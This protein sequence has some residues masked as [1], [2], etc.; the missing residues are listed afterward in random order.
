[1]DPKAI[2]ETVPPTSSSN[3]AS[4]TSPT[5]PRT[6]IGLTGIRPNVAAT[7]VAA[8][9][10]IW[11]IAEVGG[12]A[13]AP[14]LT[15]LA[16]APAP[17]AIA[18]AWKIPA[19]PIPSPGSPAPDIGYNPPSWPA[20]V[21]APELAIIGMDWIWLHNNRP[22]VRNGF[23]LNSRPKRA[24]CSGI[25]CQPLATASKS[26]L[27]RLALPRLLMA[28]SKRQPWAKSFKTCCGSLNPVLK[29][30]LD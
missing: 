11:P 12:L 20:S 24:A 4:S 15:P 18:P 27:H 19:S 29:R 7:G 28:F 9:A 14:A 13:N 23:S 8:P 21:F 2:L 10:A 25:E 22:V 30:V 5:S 6:A 16:K 17:A 3:S 1:M 26:P